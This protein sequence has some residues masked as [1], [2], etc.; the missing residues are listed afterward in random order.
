MHVM[1]MRTPGP[2]LVYHVHR[3]QHGAAAKGGGNYQNTNRSNAD[4]VL[5]QSDA[6]TIPSRC[7]TGGP[8]CPEDECPL[9]VPPPPL[10]KHGPKSQVK[11]VVQRPPRA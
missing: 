7:V 9:H 3:V 1:H 11:T 10:R 5:I 2:V 6:E 4:I 8:P